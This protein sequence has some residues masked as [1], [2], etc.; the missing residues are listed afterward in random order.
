MKLCSIGHLEGFHYKPRI[1][2]EALSS[3]SEGL[4]VLSACLGGEISQH[5][6]HDRY[7]EVKAAALRYKEA[8][9]AD[10]YLELQDHGLL[11]QKK[12]I[13][14]ML[15]LADETGI[16]LAATNDVHYLQ[17]EDAALQDLLICIGMGKTVDDSN[18]MRMMTDQLYFKS[19]S[20]MA[21]LFRHVPR[22]IENTVRIAG[23][24]RL[25]L[26]L[27]RSV[28]PVFN[29]LPDG[30]DAPSYLRQLCEQGLADRYPEL[31]AVGQQEAGEA[32]R[33]RLDYEL[34][35][36]GSMGFSDYFLIVWDFIRFAHSRG[37]RTGPGRGSSAGSLVAYVLHITDVAP[38]RHKLL[39]ER[40]L[41]PERIS[42]PDIDIDFN[43]ERRDEV[44][45]Y[46]SDKYGTEHVAQ[47]IT[48]G[49]MAAKAA[50]R[51]VGRH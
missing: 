28:L 30:L 5:L 41:N 51:D 19:Q 8:L 1:D 32:A 42:M 26:E 21:E 22:A 37:I 31:D 18:R 14:G 15:K 34:S 2:M 11:E 3:H 23:Q 48:F 10:F 25:E 40:F 17:Q 47:I 44:I 50:V 39:F 20:E 9:G 38:I 24:C 29:P 43:D 33:A 46:V 27:G 13:Q 49:T 16:E 6:L 35:V 36:I 4:I 7:E 12:V 45:A